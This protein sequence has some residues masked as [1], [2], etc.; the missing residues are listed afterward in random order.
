MADRSPY[1]DRPSSHQLASLFIFPG[2]WCLAPSLFTP[3]ALG[4][5]DTRT[6]IKLNHLPHLDAS[7]VSE[8]ER[9]HSGSLQW[10]QTVFLTAESSL[11]SKERDWI[12]ISTNTYREVTNQKS[13][14]RLKLMSKLDLMKWAHI[15]AYYEMLCSLCYTMGFFYNTV[16][17]AFIIGKQILFGPCCSWISLLSQF[18]R[19]FRLDVSMNHCD[20]RHWAQIHEWPLPTHAICTLSQRTGLG[21]SVAQDQVTYPQRI[22]IRFSYHDY[23]GI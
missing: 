15:P 20:Y 3:A 16:C 17:T 19:L 10:P 9:E 12:H 14:I 21:C 7:W 8:K 18:A 13:H 6:I 5:T 22:C 1:S 2:P 11:T 23:S 4:H